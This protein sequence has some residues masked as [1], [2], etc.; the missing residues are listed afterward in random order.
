MGHT[1]YLKLIDIFAY[2]EKKHGAVSVLTVVRNLCVAGTNKR[3]RPVKNVKRFKL[4][5]AHFIKIYL[6]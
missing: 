4:H 6:L 2:V 5:S 1:F 3:F